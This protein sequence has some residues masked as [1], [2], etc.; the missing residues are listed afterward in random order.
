MRGGSM[1]TLS[2]MEG[3]G[4]IKGAVTQRPTHSRTAA[5]PR[6]QECVTSRVGCTR[7]MDLMVLVGMS[8]TEAEVSGT[9]VHKEEAM[10]DEGP[11]SWKGAQKGGERC[12]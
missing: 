9:L 2:R 1:A 4:G 3:E 11:G 12:T 6:I 5:V 7:S 10:Q 8:A